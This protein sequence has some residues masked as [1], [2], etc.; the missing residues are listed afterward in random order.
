ML[1]RASALQNSERDSIAPRRPALGG[2]DSL[3]LGVRCRCLFRLVKE[4]EGEEAKHSLARLS[5]SQ[6]PVLQSEA[7]VKGCG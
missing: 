5:G 2:P 3:A 4:E 7:Y 6:A 1:H